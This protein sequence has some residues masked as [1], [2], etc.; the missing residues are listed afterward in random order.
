MKGSRRRTW[1]LPRVA[2]AKLRT[3]HFA[4]SYDEEEIGC[5]GAPSLI[6]VSSRRATRP[7]TTRLLVS[8]ACA[9]ISAHKGA[10]WRL[11]HLHR[12]AQTRLLAATH[13]VN[14]VAAAGEFITF[15]DMADQKNSYDE[16]FTI[17]HSTG[18]VN[19]ATGGSVQHRRRGGRKYDVRTPP[20]VTTESFVGAY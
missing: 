19:L 16:S 20:Q 11:R 14:A 2:E 7:P 9:L 1:L 18:S 12:R 8:P 10:H 6:E 4:F 5:I 15:T 17:P 3:L 13:G